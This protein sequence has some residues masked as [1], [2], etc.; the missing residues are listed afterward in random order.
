LRERDALF[1]LP[2]AFSPFFLTPVAGFPAELFANLSCAE[3]G[4]SKKTALASASATQPEGFPISNLKVAPLPTLRDTVSEIE[5]C[6]RA[7]RPPRN[8]EEDVA[9]GLELALQPPKVL[10]GTHRLVVQ[11]QDDVAALHAQVGGK[12]A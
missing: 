12:A 1:L 6:E 9:A 10:H 8:E 7:L 5:G 2:S 11:S 3:A 4:T